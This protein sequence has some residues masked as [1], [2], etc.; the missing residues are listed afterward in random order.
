MLMINDEIFTL[1]MSQI[2][3]RLLLQHLSFDDSNR[4]SERKKYD[5]L[6]PIRKVFQNFVDNKKKLKYKS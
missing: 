4:D 3:F 5:K 6:A 2:R 1:T